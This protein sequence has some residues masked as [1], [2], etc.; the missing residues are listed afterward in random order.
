MAHFAKLDDNNNVIDVIVIH[1]NELLDTNGTE[2][3]EVGIS[4]LVNWSG[5]HAQ[6]KQTS[7]NSNFRKNYA[8][9]GYYYDSD[10]DAFI[11]PKPFPSWQLNEE[12]CLWNPPFNS[13]DNEKIYRWNEEEYKW[14]EIDSNIH[15]I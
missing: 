11:P 1:N 3:E 4:F 10:R 6:W 12:T 15:N 9:V 7:Y 8:G 5:G 13:P 14:D 2:R